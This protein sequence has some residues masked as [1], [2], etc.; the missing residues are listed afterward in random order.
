MNTEKK[1]RNNWLIIVP[2]ALASLLGTYWLGSCNA[3]DAEP[4]TIVE[5][6]ASVIVVETEIVEVPGDT[7]V[8][9]ATPEPT[10]S[11]EE[12]I[13]WFLQARKHLPLW[14]LVGENANGDLLFAKFKAVTYEKDDIIVAYTGKAEGD[15]AE[16]YRVDDHLAIAEAS[17]PNAQGFSCPA[18]EPYSD[19]TR[20]CAD[21]SKP[22]AEFAGRWKGLWLDADGN[23]RG[24]VYFYKVAGP[25]G[26]GLYARADAVTMPDCEDLFLVNAPPNSCNQ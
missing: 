18:E 3:P 20:L 22:E 15:D 9:T 13:F 7:R 19:V 24:E 21:G 14:E 11:P 8:V 26:P 4:V 25:A 5:T 2:L 10:A 1:Q 6:A 16:F 17:F 23:E 12:H